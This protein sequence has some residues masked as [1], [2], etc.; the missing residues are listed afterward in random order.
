M[1][2]N[3]N[4]LE[5]VDSCL[6]K[7]FEE[8]HGGMPDSGL[9]ERVVNEVEKRVIIKTLRFTKQNRSKASKILG[10]NRNTLRKKLEAY[11]IDV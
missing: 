9:Y 11:N 3:S 5:L 7:F 8:H 2:T 6:D 10:I 1:K 4:L